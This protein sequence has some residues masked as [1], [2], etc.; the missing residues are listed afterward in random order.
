MQDRFRGYREALAAHGRAFDPARVLSRIAEPDYLGCLRDNV[1]AVVAVN[2]FTAL[3]LLQDAA[4]AGVRVPGDLAVV[5]FDD[6][7]QAAGFS[8]TTVAQ[9]SFEIGRRAAELL[10]GR[11]AGEADPF[12]RVLLPTRLVVRGSSGES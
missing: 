2:D 8:L 3:E 7:P 12:Q 4:G 1:R 10:I 5:G 11:L 9:P 6:L